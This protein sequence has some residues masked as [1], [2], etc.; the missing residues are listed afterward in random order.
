VNAL[1]IL[2]Q[3]FLTSRII[4]WLGLP[5][6]IF[7]KTMNRRTFMAA[8]GALA[9]GI[10]FGPQRV[11]GA[12]FAPIRKPIPSTGELLAAMG[13]GTSRTFDVRDQPETMRQLAEV[14]QV[15]FD[16]GGTL[17]DSSPMYGRLEAVVGDLVQRVGRKDYFAAT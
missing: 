1:T 3:V 16:N 11:P 4:R 13:M 7:D 8:A 10:A 14:L 17:I 12:G 5:W 15:F 9:A 2:I 6:N